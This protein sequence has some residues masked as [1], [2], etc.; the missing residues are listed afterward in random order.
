MGE[1]RLADRVAIATGAAHGI[2]RAICVGL[3]REGASVWACDI[4]AD[5]LDE[6]R[7]AT[8]R[9]VRG[10]CRAHVV[11]ATDS[12]R[13]ASFVGEVLAADGRVDILVNTAGGVAGQSMRPIEVV[14]DADWHRIFAIN[15]DAAF[16]F[17]HAVASSMKERRRGSIVNISSGAGRS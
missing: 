6:T 10:A 8:D 4:L 11:D 5:E 2:G 15:L 9:V 7:R 17:T 16:H 12:A 1:G 13:V 3:A 14:S